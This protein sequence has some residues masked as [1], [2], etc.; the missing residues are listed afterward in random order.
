MAPFNDLNLYKSS[1]LVG[2]GVFGTIEQILSN[3]RVK[4]YIETVFAQSGTL[5]S[6]NIL[7]IYYE[8][9]NLVAS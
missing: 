6:E 5:A 3:I 2:N 4:S 7:E 8:M 9:V 1:N